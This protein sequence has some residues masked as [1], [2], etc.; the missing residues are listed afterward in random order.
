[1]THTLTTEKRLEQYDSELE[2]VKR[3]FTEALKHL[4][5][6]PSTGES[7]NERLQVLGQRLNQL[8]HALRPEDF[9]KEQGFALFRAFFTI[10]DLIDASPGTPDLDTCNEL[11]INIE[12][13]RHVMRDA[14][15]E[16]VTGVADDQRLVLTDLRRWLPTTSQATLAG[17]DR[18]RPA[19][20]CIAGLSRL[21]Y[22]LHD[23]EWSPGSSP[24]FITAGLKKA[25]SPG[26]I[27]RV[28]IWM[29]VGRGSFSAMRAPKTRLSRPPARDVRNMPRRRSPTGRALAG[30][31]LS[32]HQL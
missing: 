17:A 30:D 18:R 31:R 13:I 15:D 5:D 10:R 20:R 19:A 28:A 7:M 27:V 26:S 4:G 23:C 9:D 11:L 16:H 8:G 2:Q 29:V 14:F 12:R 25:S 6:E 1:M 21:G 24:F 32:R 22:C 3:A